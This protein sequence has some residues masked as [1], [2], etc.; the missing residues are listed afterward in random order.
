M[1]KY[2]SKLGGHNIPL[3]PR[4]NLSQW[5]SRTMHHNNSRKLACQLTLINSVIS[6]NSTWQRRAAV[7][8]DS[9]SRPHLVSARK[10]WKCT[11]EFE[12]VYQK[13]AA[14]SH[15]SKA[16]VKHTKKAPNA[17]SHH[18]QP[19]C[20]LLSFKFARCLG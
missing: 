10:I 18:C 2:I 14:L 17:T 6:T 13:R 3:D 7:K 16:H 15:L 20:Y 11:G 5:Q 1:N 12:C 8:N 9:N 4:L 19:H